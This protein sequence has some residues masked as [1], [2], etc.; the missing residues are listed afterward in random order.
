MARDSKNKKIGMVLDAAFPPD[1]RVKKEAKTL[2]NA[3]FDVYLLC[4]AQGGKPNFEILNGLKVHR[5]NVSYGYIIS[6]F[7]SIIYALTF[8]HP[9]WLKA[10]GKFVKE[11]QISILHVHDLPLVNTALK[12]KEKYKII[13]VADLHENYP[14]ALQVWGMWVRNP[15][16]KAVNKVL[17]DYHRW[18]E[19]EKKVLSKTDKIIVVIDEM[20]E[21]LITTHKIPPEKI[22]V[23]PN[24]SELSFVENA[25]IYNGIIEKYK[26]RFVIS[27]IG[28]FGPH[29]G[30]DTAISGMGYVKEK[31]PK[32]LLLLVG[33]RRKEV[34]NRLKNL[35]VRYNLK[36][37]IEFI[38]WQSFDKVFSYMQVSNIGIVPHNKNEDTDHTN[39]HKLFQYMM[40]GKP[41][42][43]SSCK[44]LKRIVETL[45]SGLVF[46]A[47]NPESF[48]KKIIELYEN[49]ELSKQLAENGRKATFEGKWNWENTSMDLIELYNNLEVIQED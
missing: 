29:R 13:V 30:L 43:V 49:N 10:V 33:R 39:P 3:G 31:I 32:S 1:I 42:V 34:G 44:P 36:E 35:V 4:V 23:V 27:F 19:H 8:L 25:K 7:C 5:T 21:R 9:L 11:N 46:E 12:I 15:L 41:V 22:V 2:I 47:G 38:G 18:I 37:N 20:K 24:T 16:R 17:F 6:K 40:V 14:A 28:S 45:N 48:A 26:D